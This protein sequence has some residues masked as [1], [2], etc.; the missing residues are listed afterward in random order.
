MFFGVRQDR[1]NDLVYREVDQMTTRMQQVFRR[2]F[3]TYMAALKKRANH[4]IL[5]GKKSGRI[6]RVR[7]AAG[8]RRRHQASAPGETHANLTGKLRKSL[9]WKVHGWQRAEFGYGVATNAKERA[10]FYAPF[11]EFGTRRMLPRPSLQNA[12]EAETPERHFDE[13]FDREF[14]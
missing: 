10:P 4:E 14:R 6:Y 11:L 3:L 5:H 8:R 12:I 9:S 7:T 13:A 1:N 2:G